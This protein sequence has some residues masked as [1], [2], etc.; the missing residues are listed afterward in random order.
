MNINALIRQASEQLA[1]AQIETPHNDARLLLA[2]ACNC[3]LSDLDKAILLGNPLLDDQS[4]ATFASYIQRR[5]A[6]EPLQYI[7]G[8]APFRYLDLAVGPGVFIPRPETEIVVE[9]AIQWIHAQQFTSP[10]IVDLCAGS[11]AIGLSLATEIPSAQVWAV[12]ND[13][14]AA[15]WTRENIERISQK[16][17]DFSSRYHLEITDATCAHTLM[18]LTNTVD[19]V[20]SNPPY[21]PQS[22]TTE[23]IEVREYDPDHA[24]Y[25]GSD[26]GMR[27]PELIIMKAS[28]LLRS[29]GLLVMEHDDTQGEKTCMFAR[30]NHFID[31]TTG[32]DLA[33][34]PRFLQAYRA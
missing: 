3:S 17:P 21:I 25:G 27:I 14:L 20:I 23:Q 4:C 8:T 28:S 13:P 26:D 32:Y 18:E 19:V 2:H 7:T 34:K 1:Q 24:L 29:G 22:R 9:A 15:R 16:D 6:R 11:G 33:A 10:R 31:C 12:E 30:A 5:A